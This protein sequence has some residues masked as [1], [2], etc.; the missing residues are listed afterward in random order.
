[1]N[2]GS[3]K[4]LEKLMRIFDRS[5][6][7]INDIDFRGSVKSSRFLPGIAKKVKFYP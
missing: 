4:F 5:I 6:T 2:Y 1:M 7:S 3:T